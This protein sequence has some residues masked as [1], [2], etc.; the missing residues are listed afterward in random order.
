MSKDVEISCRNT[1]GIVYEFESLYDAINNFLSYEGYRVS[2]VSKDFSF[3]LYRDELPMIT[4]GFDLGSDS[5][6]YEA[7]VVCFQKVNHE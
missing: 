4:K 6:K 7:R 5:K 1:D 2:M 3:H